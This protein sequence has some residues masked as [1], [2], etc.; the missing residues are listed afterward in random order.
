MN[1]SE[2]SV[3]HCQMMIRRPIAEV[4]D[5]FINPA[6][7]TNF[8]FTK[9]TG[10]LQVGQP[11]TWEWEMYDVSDEIDV[12]E[13]LTDEKIM[14]QWGDPKTTVVFNFSSLSAESTYVV[15]ENYGF[16][17]SG[18]ALAQDLINNTGGFTTVLDGCKAWLEHG[19]NLNLIVDKFPPGV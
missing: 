2:N 1:P 3:I 5:A 17:T 4:F 13:I 8:W 19:I 12:L 15:I 10:S 7:T 6:I 16:T 14:I 11:V 9:S 18:E